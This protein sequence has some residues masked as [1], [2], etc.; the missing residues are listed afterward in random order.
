MYKRIWLV[1]V[2]LMALSL[3]GGRAIATGGTKVWGDGV[4]AII[5]KVGVNFFASGALGTVRSE[6]DIEGQ[7]RTKSIGCWVDSIAGDAMVQCIATT[8]LANVPVDLGL[9][10]LRCIS[11]DPAMVAAVGA[12]NSDSMITFQTPNAPPESA[13]AGTCVHIKVENVSIY[14]VKSP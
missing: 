8:D 9:T 14:N 5:G 12:M 1:V 13:T 10:S 3:S 4:D 11:H 2:P 7:V 6:P